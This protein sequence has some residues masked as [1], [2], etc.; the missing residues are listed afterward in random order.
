MRFARILSMQALLLSEYCSQI[1]QKQAVKLPT[2][3]DMT[4]K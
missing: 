2:T 3:P 1:A 4:N